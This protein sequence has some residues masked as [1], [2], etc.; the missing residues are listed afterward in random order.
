VYPGDT[1][2]RRDDSEYAEEEDGEEDGDERER[3]EREEPNAGNRAEPVSHHHAHGKRKI[4]PI[5]PE[6]SMF[7]LDSTNWYHFIA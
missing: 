3:G 1:T 6:S 4:K 2:D 5:P 7:I